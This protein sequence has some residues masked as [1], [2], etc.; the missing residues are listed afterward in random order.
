MNPAG[1]ANESCAVYLYGRLNEASGTHGGTVQEELLFTPE[2]AAAT[3]KVGRTKTFELIQTGEL[4][5]IVIGRLRRIPAD[6]LTS[7][8]A[9]LRTEQNGAASCAA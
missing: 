1:L 9:K 3:L 4:E 7:Y 5:S 2:E 8:V 6:A